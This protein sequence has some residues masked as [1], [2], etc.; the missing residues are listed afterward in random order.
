MKSSGKNNILEMRSSQSGWEPPMV[1][2]KEIARR[3]AAEMNITGRKA[4][5]Y[6]F[7]IIPYIDALYILFDESVRPELIRRFCVHEGYTWD[8][9]DEKFFHGYCIRSDACLCLSKLVDQIY[10]LYSAEHPE[11]HLKRYYTHNLRLLDHVYHCMKQNTVKEMLYKAGLDELAVYIDDLDVIDLMA[12]K[13]SDLY[14]GLSMRVLRALNNKDGAA[15]LSTAERRTYIRELNTKY[16]DIFD[17]PLNEAHC[18]YLSMLI[19]GKL[20]PGETGRLFRKKKTDYDYDWC[21]SIF[22]LK[23]AGERNLLDFAAFKE[24]FSREIAV[25]DLIYRD[26][27]SSLKPTDDLTQAKTIFWYLVTKKKEYNRRFR[28]S[29]RLRL[30]EW[31]ERTSEFIIRYP[32]TVNDFLRESVFMQNCLHAYIE[33]VV[34]NDTTVMF[35]RKADNVNRPFITLEVQKN[36]LKQAYHRFNRD[37]TRQEAE[38][39]TAWCGRHGIRTGRFQFNALVD[40]LD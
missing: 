39:I 9:S 30:Y 20:L 8:F 15:L 12:T 24:D 10:R 11:W 27:L 35:M 26:Y 14:D 37:C 36:E 21:R 33:A 3:A 1:N 22:S 7:R 18:C 5:M 19:K 13:P 34:D 16:P 6:I 29:N 38:W 32:Q 17:T 40:E 25:H 2:Q 4:C 23:M 28:V 31:Q